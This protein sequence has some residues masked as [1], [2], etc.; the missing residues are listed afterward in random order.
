MNTRQK[1]GNLGKKLQPNA[2]TPAFK[3]VSLTR[4]GYNV[5]DEKVRAICIMQILHVLCG[6]FGISATQCEEFLQLQL[7]LLY[8]FTARCV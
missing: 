5:A 6:Y 2:T 1:L 8:I 3:S 4:V 7:R